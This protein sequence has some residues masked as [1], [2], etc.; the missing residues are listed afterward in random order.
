MVSGLPLYGPDFFRPTIVTHESLRSGRRPFD[1]PAP[2]WAVSPGALRALGITVLRGREFTDRDVASA[3]RVAMVNV[4]LAQQLWPDQNPIGRE[5]AFHS[6]AASQELEDKLSW[7]EIVAVVNDIAGPLTGPGGRPTVIVPVAQ[8]W[9]S[10]LFMVVARAETHPTPQLA[11]SLKRAIVQADPEGR[12]DVF[13]TSTMDRLLGELLYQR[14]MAVA[15]LGSS[16]IAGL[17]LALIGLYGVIAYSIEQRRREI[18]IR[19]ALGATR[20]DVT[21]L[22]L[23]EG[24]WITAAGSAIGIGISGLTLRAAIGLGGGS[25]VMPSTDVWTYTSVPAL[26]LPIVLLACYLP[27]WRASR[28]N[29]LIALRES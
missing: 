19:M 21:R 26:V 2:P 15:I 29:P 1:G 4:T 12:A 13:Q 10:W 11:E 27:A 3:P 16:G 8:G 28:A 25:G 17:V 7:Y 14:R 18:G 24:V 22:V 9:A 20:R 6:N 5:I 23:R